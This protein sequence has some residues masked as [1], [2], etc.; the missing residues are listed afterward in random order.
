MPAFLF[1]HS[2]CRR[3]DAV[4]CFHLVGTEAKLGGDVAGI[5]V[6]APLH[7]LVVVVEFEHGVYRRE[8][9][10]VPTRHRDVIFAFGEHEP[11]V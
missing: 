1:R 8:D 6:F 3:C 2:I 4:E 7:N 10:L 9:A 11:V 5:P